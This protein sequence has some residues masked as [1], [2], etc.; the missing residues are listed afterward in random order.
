MVSTKLTLTDMR[1][2]VMQCSEAGEACG[3][4]LQDA[5]GNWR[6]APTPVFR[7][8]CTHLSRP[9]VTVWI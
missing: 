2:Q 7:K 3:N 4:N 9:A 6:M 1:V 5:H 8:R